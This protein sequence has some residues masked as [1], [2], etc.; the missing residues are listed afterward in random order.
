[1]PLEDNR[2]DA[3][4]NGGWDCLKTVRFCFFFMARR[5]LP[6]DAEEVNE[7]YMRNKSYRAVRSPFEL[8]TLL[9]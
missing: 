9:R 4:E 7:N 6:K 8:A 1:M 5:I 3:A 2:L